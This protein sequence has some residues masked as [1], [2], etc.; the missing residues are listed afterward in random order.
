MNIRSIRFGLIFS[1]FI[2]CSCVSF[3]T[4]E[5]S[6]ARQALEAAEAVGASSLAAIEY[7][8]ARIL[9]KD[10][11]R[12]IAEGRYELAKKVAKKAKATAMQAR[13]KAIDLAQ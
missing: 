8:E 1:A 5:L 2:L 7:Q 9:L 4:Q 10:A 12:F 3:P 11:D 13:R 6:D